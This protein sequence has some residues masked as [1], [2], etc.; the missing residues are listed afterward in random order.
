MALDDKEVLKEEKQRFEAIF[1]KPL[2]HTKNS[3]SK[4]KLPLVYR[5]LIDLEITSDY[6]MGYVSEAG[7]RAGTCT[8]FYFY[9]LDYEM[10]TPLKINS[11]CVLDYVFRNKINAS[12]EIKSLIDAVKKVN[13]IF[14]LVVHNYTF[15]E[16]D[17]WKGWKKTYIELLDYSNK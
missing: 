1:N 7:F 12:A 10:Q 6:T 2:M 16:D 5:N 11:F 17:Q 4:L 14:N 3:F 9:D 13:G 15:S 8:P